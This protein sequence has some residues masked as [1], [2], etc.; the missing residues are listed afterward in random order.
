MI[1]DD[2][3]V[4]PLRFQMYVYYIS[5]QPVWRSAMNENDETLNHT[6]YTNSSG[7]TQLVRLGIQV[8]NTSVDI[9][10]FLVFLVGGLI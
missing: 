6:L 8:Y 7:T 2:P 4:E 9:K 10:R 1:S 3:G 5:S